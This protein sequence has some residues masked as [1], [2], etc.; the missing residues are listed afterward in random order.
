MKK[1]VLTLISLLAFV[2][3]HAQTEEELNAWNDVNVY[4]INRLYPRTNVVPEGE[5][6]SQCLNGDWK[7]Q[8]VDS[9]SK[10]PVDFYKE[11]YNASGW[12]T[13]KVPANWELNGYGTPIYVNVDNEFRPNEPPFAPMVDNPVG[14]YLTEFNIPEAWKDRLT[15]INFGAVKSAYYVWVNG[16]FV[17]FTEDAKTNAEFDLTP[18]VRVG[19]NTLAVK[20]YRFSNGSYFECQDFWRLSGIERDVT[21]YSKPTLNIYDYEIHAGLD[22]T[23]Q[24]GTFAIKVKLQSKTNK[25]QKGSTLIVGAYEGPETKGFPENILFT[26][27]KPLKELTFTQADDDYYYAEAELSVD[28]KEIGKVKPWSAESPTLYQLRMSLMDKKSRAIEKLTSSFGFRTSEIKDGKLLINGQYVLIKGVNRHEHDPYTG[29]VISRE[30]MERDIALMKQMNINTVRTCHYPDD[31]YWYELCDKY[32]LYVWDEANCESHAQGYGDRSLAKDPQYRDMIWSR[33]RNMLERDKNHPS[34][35][36][37][38]M[39]NECGNGVNFEYTYDWMKDRDPSRP[40]TYERAIYDRNTDVIGLMYASPKYLQRFVDEGL[41]SVY[42]RPFIMV[43]YCHAMGNSMGGLQDYWDVIE[44]NEQLQG[45]CIWDWVDQS[46]IQHD[47]DKDVDWLAVGGDLGHAYGVGDD[48]AFCANGVVSSDRTPH[49]H[50]AE[51]KKVYQPIKFTAKDLTWCKFEAKNW[52]S[53]TNASAFDCDYEIFSAEKTLTKGKV[54]LN[55]EPFGT[56]EINLERLRIYG[57]PGEEFFIR[58]SVKTKEDQPFIP[59]GTEVAY[60]EFKLVD[61]PSAPLEPL[62]KE[63]QVQYNSG[64]GTVYNEDFTVTFD[65]TSGAM[66]SFVVKGQ[67]LLKGELSDNFWR[68]PTLND[69]VDGW[70]LPRWKKAGLQ[71]LTAKNGGLHFERMDGNTV[72]VN[73]AVEY[74]DGMGQLQIVVNK[75]YLID[76]EGNISIT[77][78]V[79]PME[80]VTSLPKVGVQFQMP[81][82]YRNLTW[83]GK[84][85]ENYPDRNASGKMGVYNVNALSLFEQHVVPQDNGNHADTRWVALTND[86]SNAGL[87]VMMPEP[88][89]FSIYNYDDANLTAARRIN[90]LNPTDFLTVNV[91]YKQAPVGTATCGPGVDEKYVLGNQVY[92][93]TV[94][95]RAFDKTQD[96]IEL[97]RFQ[98]PEAT[99]MMLPT[100]VIKALMAGKE[101]FRMYNRPLTISMTCA[102]PK[103]EIRYTTDGSEPTEKSSLYKSSFVI[104]KTCTVKAKAFKKGSVPSFVAL[105]QFNRLNIKNTT[106]VTPPAERYGKDADIALMDGKKGY[107][108]DWQNDWLGFEGVDM[109]ATIELAVPTKINMVKVGLGHEPNDWVVWPKGVWVS[110][111]SDGEEFSDWERAE[112]PVFDRPDKMQGF[113]RVEARLRTTGKQW[114]YV[115]VKVENQGVL[116]EWHPYAGQKAWIMVDEVVIE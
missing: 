69:E 23:Y 42:H 89:N 35:I 49:H 3:I 76:G 115:R 57:N 13:L 46:F 116:P 52:L 50:A 64:S 110:F 6:W 94:L 109:E 10:A 12:K 60:D 77:N 63:K 55:I 41:D 97:T 2:G 66:T 8:W 98:V 85:T 58:F 71:H 47:K 112:L 4:E 101:D 34:V 21:L 103:A 104:L 99:A 17:G 96:P 38:S 72:S 45:G 88:F 106:F 51:V 39:G 14:C 81:L 67:E 31:P 107:P 93:Y 53:F 73:A 5:Q 48:D 27:T 28:S 61:W 22:K 44:A 68:A 75:V 33:N 114:K 90:Q 84:D 25:I 74:Y 37:W 32:G 92:E 29:H 11:G 43:E 56:Q 62:A 59:A 105:R 65:R 78:R 79:E 7:F 30:S 100:P 95:L 87:F 113:G 83:F 24:N 40:V 108:G 111:S 102:D 91:D 82:D 86:N 19:K 16:Q 1:T 54:D 80:T 15:F 18:Y 26:L 70:A 36:M 20:V 9:P